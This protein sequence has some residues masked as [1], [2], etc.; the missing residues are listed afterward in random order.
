MKLVYIAGPFRA[1]LAWQMEHHV[2]NAE[3]VAHWMMQKCRFLYPV[4]PMA[5][6]RFFHGCREDDYFLQGTL[7][8][9]SKCDAMLLIGAWQ[10]SQGACLE[11]EQM[12]ELRNPVFEHFDD[13]VEWHDQIYRDLL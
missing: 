7:L 4:I 12:L 3:N 11:R 6:T 9:M 8:M 10:E 2:R 1:P 13:L 5:N